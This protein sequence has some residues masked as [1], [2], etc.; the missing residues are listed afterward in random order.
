[1]LLV[2]IVKVK[3]PAVIVCEP[4]VYT[5]TALLLCDELYINSVSKAVLNVTLAYVTEA[6]GVQYAVPA[7][8]EVLVEAGAVAL[9]IVTPP[10]VYPVPVTSP[11]VV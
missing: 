8:A 4:N 5:P 11:V 6:E 1:V 10:A 9:V 7:V 3:L 2:G